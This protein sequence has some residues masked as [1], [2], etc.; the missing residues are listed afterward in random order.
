MEF[1]EHVQNVLNLMVVITVLTD[2]GPEPETIQPFEGEATPPPQV[3]E[4]VRLSPPSTPEV[5]PPPVMIPEDPSL[6]PIELMAPSPAGGLFTHTPTPYTSMALLTLRS[7][8]FHGSPYAKEVR[9]PHWFILWQTL[10]LLLLL[11]LLFTLVGC[12]LTHWKVSVVQ[13]NTTTGVFC[14]FQVAPVVLRQTLRPPHP[15]GKGAGPARERG[16][17][18]GRCLESAS[19]RWTER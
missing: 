10:L 12:Q 16:T 3:T 19:S 2:L 7:S 6:P 15:A 17:S 1:S 4:E 9:V 8:G 5:G 11:L 18:T 14:V 13:Y